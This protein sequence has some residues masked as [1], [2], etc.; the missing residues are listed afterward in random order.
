MS[1]QL[2]SIAILCTIKDLVDIIVKETGFKGTIKWDTSKPNG[3][4]RRKL[5]TT[6][7]KAEFGFESTT[8]FPEGLKN[9]IAWYKEHHG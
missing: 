3:Q 7:A 8:T 4:P 6:R 2:K 1:V 5:D 9:T